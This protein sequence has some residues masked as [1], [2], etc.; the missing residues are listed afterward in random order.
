M[1]GFLSAAPAEVNA[2]KSAAPGVSSDR[3]E[4]C[5]LGLEGLIRLGGHGVVRFQSDSTVSTLLGADRRG[6]AIPL[7]RR[8]IQS[9]GLCDEE[10]H[11][12][13][14]VSRPSFRK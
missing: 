14:L 8:N 3:P 9:F 7:S 10:L 6:T 4:L 5:R 13:K 2:P 1:L 11:V 12:V